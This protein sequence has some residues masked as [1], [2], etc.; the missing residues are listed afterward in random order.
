[1]YRVLYV[2]DE[3]DL[4]EL[5]KIFLEKDGDIAI[6]TTASG[7]AALALLPAA[8]FDAIV[9]DFQ[10]PGMNG[11]ELLKA[12]RASA[13]TIPFILFTG[14]GREEVVVDALNNGADFYLQ[15]GGDPTAQFTE[16][17]H[18]IR[19]AVS[20]R[21]AEQALAESESRFRELS[22]LLPQVVFETD[23]K[24]TL[25]YAN[26]IAFELFGY[27]PAE[28]EQG[29]NIIQMI[30]PQDRKRATE[31]FFGILEGREPASRGT[32][33][34]ALR[35]DGSTFP[36]SIY[37]SPIIIGSRKA[38]LRGIIVNITE[39]QRAETDLQESERR[40][41]LFMEHLPAAAFIKDADGTLVFS[42]TYLNDLFGWQDPAG[43]STFD[44]LPRDVAGQMAEDDR[45]AL[46]QGGVSKR[47]TVT[48]SKGVE[49]VFS[50]TKF[51]V[52]DSAGRTLLGGISLD[53]T[54]IHRA[55]EAIRE[56]EARLQ[57]ILRGSPSLQ[58][59]IDRDHR[60][61]SWNKALEAYSG[62]ESAD[63]IG[64]DQQWQAFYPEKRPVLADVL[65]DGDPDAVERWYTGKYRKSRY[66]EGAYE[67]VDFFPA[68]GA[69]GVWLAFTAAPIRD[70]AGTIIGA[71]E[72][73]EDVTERID[74]KNT[75]QK[76]EQRYRE[77][78]NTV[79]D[80]I[81]IHDIGTFGFVFVNETIEETFGYTPE[82]AL[83]LSLADISSNVPPFTEET[84]AE[85]LKRAA[86]GEPQV[87]EWHCRHK[88]GHLFWSE[89]SLRR[90]N[91]A[92]RDYILA[93]ERDITDRKR[94]EEA[95]RESEE[96]YRLLVE[97]IPF[98]ITLMDADR[99][100]IMSNAAQGRMFHT[101]PGLWT[102]R[103]CYRE[104][105]KR[106]TVCPHCPGTRAMATGICCDMETEGVRDDGTRFNA[107]V[108]AIP[109][110]DPEGRI[111]GFMEMVEDIT[112]RKRAED[113][114]RESEEK[115]RML[116]E[117][118]QDIIYSLSIDGTILYV[119]PQA[120]EQL[121]YRPEEMEGRPFTDFIHPDDAPALIDF[122]RGHSGLKEAGFFD[123][124]RVRRKDGTYRWFEDKSIYLVDYEG[125]EIVVGTIGDI[126]DRKRAE[127]T[128]R[129]SEDRF[130]RAIAG[131][132]AGLWDWDI[133]NDRVFFSLQWKS[134]LGYE[135]H[136]IADNF[137]GWKD[138]WHPDDAAR[139]E[140]T[141]NDY[142][143]GRTPVY[144]VE[145][146]LRHKDGSWHW[147]LTRGD[148]Q[149]DEA[150]RPVR[151]TG[152]NIDITGR[153]LSEEALHEASARLALATRAGGVGV[154]DYDICKN[155]LVWDDQMYTIYG[156]SRNTF[157]GAYESWRAGVH[158][159][160]TGRC[161]HDVQMALRGEKEF[162]IEFRVV[163]PDGSVHDVRALAL[164]QR[165]SAGNPVRMIGTNWD[166]TDRKRAEEALRES[167][168]KYRA[169]VENMEDMFY[170]TDP[171]GRIVMV[172]PSAAEF[173]GFS[174]SEEL[175]GVNIRQFY[176]SPADRDL[177]L[178]ELEK[179]GS[180][181]GF[182]LQ[183]QRAD[184]TLR[185]ITASSHF[186]SDS[187]GERAGVE[188]VLHDVT[189][190]QE[191][192]RALQE[193][194]RKLTLLTSIA[195]HDINNHL[196]ALDGFLDLLHSRVSDPALE[197]YFVRITTAAGRIAAMIRFTR[198][199]DALGVNAPGWQ[200]ARL[201]VNAAADEA[202]VPNTRI[203]NEI[204]QG[205]VIFADPL[206]GRVF[207]NLVDNAVR[208][209]GKITMIRFWVQESGDGAIIFCEDDGNGIAAEEKQKIFDRGFGRNTGL[210]L[211]LSREILSIT[212]ITIRET[213]EPGKGARFEIVVPGGAG[214]FVQED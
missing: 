9:S 108:S 68:M 184:G 149:K 64:T 34:L 209:A 190:L 176:P 134:M 194:N 131:T 85:H 38:G 126:T 82:E 106:D 195:R 5:G 43:K 192:G 76:S 1:M 25:T 47:E 120:V 66:V 19:L 163:W 79:N 168:E 158:P 138:L 6:D 60:V 70:R 178:A 187:A 95:R 86:A 92:G 113:A 211:F 140:K 7:T 188:G 136:E 88:D 101:D 115:Y 169:I 210:G 119:S 15:K 186:Y 51:A 159:G 26:R 208:H 170:R 191:A 81:W 49:R 152:T 133:V 179:T 181:R 165:D 148:I 198:E 44:L 157:G 96:R 151:W 193:A 172:S 183:F 71:V 150:G 203:I 182:P 141:I 202:A 54:G 31:T 174:G 142:L 147:I 21:R 61:I 97:N 41:A 32:V 39:R 20:R 104:F 22:E 175:I 36:I 125:R 118:N 50:T 42:N 12:V 33:Y 161:D 99:R 196:F 29:L 3:P 52:P 63:I 23:A 201:L 117:V 74:A 200:E 75:L 110:S 24:G 107:R 204:P 84:A 127:D 116:V 135:D 213:G 59:V 129:E 173:T 90:R 77:I 91:I 207:F 180:V 171:E 189:E 102:G 132:G 2:D 87:F 144:E 199:Y 98:G 46:A 10:M 177:F 167:E 30:A 156:I 16:L 155:L 214:R 67:A 58:F 130:S 14:R 83:G 13:S 166:I 154:W 105:E 153:K 89:V 162:D 28:F 212:G 123:Q 80:T 62:I 94:A 65:V 73:L 164:V 78:F 35:K 57:S 122:L 27:T 100:I 69:A 139:I 206:I 124:F 55:E 11:I 128:L 146:R 18:K 112:D 160:D 17:A 137:S 40:F 53:I 93:I 45:A 185:A 145:H 205:A 197:P 56:S 4:L 8:E 109:L 103:Y 121:R 143:E 114:L 37:G 48:D 72:T 111:T